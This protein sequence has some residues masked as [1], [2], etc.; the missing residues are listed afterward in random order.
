MRLRLSIN[1]LWLIKLHKD[2][3]VRYLGNPLIGFPRPL[4]ILLTLKISWPAGHDQG[5]AL[6]TRNL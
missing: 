4:L 6:G 1:L 2:K 5:S 3:F